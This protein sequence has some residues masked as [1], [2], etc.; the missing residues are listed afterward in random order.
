LQLRHW[1][2]GE[3]QGDLA[4]LNNACGTAA[5]A[6]GWACVYP[7][8]KAQGLG[9]YGSGPEFNSEVSWAAT[10]AFFEVDDYEAQSLFQ[11]AAYLPAP[12]SEVA[13][14]FADEDQ[15][16]ERQAVRRRIRRFLTLKG[17]I[18]P[19]RNAELAAE[20]GVPA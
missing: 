15:L 6:V 8:F 2:V 7:P 1:R 17:A 20:E 16:T 3:E 5:C 19:E 18:T 12:R 9:R 13:E 4:L 11:S 10:M 14:I